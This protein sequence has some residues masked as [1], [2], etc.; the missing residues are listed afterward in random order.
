MA[1]CNYVDDKFFVNYFINN[2]VISHSD[3]VTTSAF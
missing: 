3:S 2:A 1:D